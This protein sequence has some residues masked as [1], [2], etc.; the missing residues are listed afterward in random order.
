MISAAE[1][2]SLELLYIIQLSII[3]YITKTKRFFSQKKSKY[4]ERD[5]KKEKSNSRSEEVEALDG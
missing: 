1:G 5:R 4:E 2:T 3:Y